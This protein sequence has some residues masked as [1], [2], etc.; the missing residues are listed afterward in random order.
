M[1]L[2]ATDIPIIFVLKSHVGD[3]VKK[4]MNYPEEELRGILLIKGSHLLRN[5]INGGTHRETLS[6]PSFPD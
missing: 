4:R 1:F 5:F 2:Q 6:K 3:F